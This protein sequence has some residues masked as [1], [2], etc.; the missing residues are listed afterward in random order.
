VTDL[1]VIR[2]AILHLVWYETSFALKIAWALTICSTV[3][4]TWCITYRAQ[5][6]GHVQEAERECRQA[7]REI[8]EYQAWAM[9]EINKLNAR[10][11]PAV[12]NEMRGHERPQ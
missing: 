12:M 10:V 7:K 11:L 1:Q 3:F 8:A 2:D 6:R 5:S 9:D 4:I